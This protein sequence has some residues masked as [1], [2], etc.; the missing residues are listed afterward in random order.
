MSEFKTYFRQATRPFRSDLLTA[1]FSAAAVSV[2]AV[3]LLGVSGWFL[4][5]A[6]I[7]GAAG[8]VAVQMFNYLLPSAAIRFLAIARTLLRYVE[9]YSGHAAA[10]RALAVVRPHLFARIA[11][12]DPQHTLKL[13]RGETSA[14]FVQDITVLENRLVAGS[15]PA[16]AI[17]GII[18][19][20]GLSLFLSP[21]AAVIFIAGLGATLG[22]SMWLGQ[23][24]AR[25][26]QAQREQA[27]LGGLKQRFFEILPL[28][29]DIAAYDL[30][31]RLLADMAAREGDLAAAKSGQISLDGLI[32]SVSLVVMGVTLAV[33]FLTHRGHDLPLLA[34]AVL[35]V[36]VGFESS[37]P[38]LKAFAQKRIFDE[39]ESRVADLYDQAMPRTTDTHAPLT[40]GWLTVGGHQSFR[41]DRD[42]R[43]L[44]SGASGA[45]KTRL[46]EM[47]MGLRPADANLGQFDRSLFAPSP[48]DATPLNGTIRDNLK[49]A[50]S[51]ESLKTRSKA[52]LD[53]MMIAALSDAQLTSKPLDLWIGDGGVSLSGGEKKRLGI[54]RALLRDAAILILD[55][56]TEGLDAATEA[57]LIASLEARLIADHRGLILI[58]HKPAPRRLCREVLNMD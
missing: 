25:N 6:A 19:A 11:A 45:G 3:C 32:Q 29:P 46:I 30:S 21:W 10:L 27:I 34:L 42:T 16:S 12:A 47:L 7:A 51:A 31:E 35:A 17:G 8:G 44:I 20:L 28:T 5:G 9:R 40:D 57:R 33:L 14:R 55:E 2:A 58:S 36:T 54:A 50:F 48:Q 41:L 18:A 52:E 56:P 26:D 15:A 4:A 53:A 43:L 38:L 13:S 23:K 49:M 22:V 37:A 1:A 39:A 24:T